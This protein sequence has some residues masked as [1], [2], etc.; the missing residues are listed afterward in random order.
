M[1]PKKKL[2]DARKLAVFIWQYKHCA[3]PKCL[4]LTFDGKIGYTPA[5]L[6]RLYD[7]TD[8]NAESLA[9]FVKTADQSISRGNSW[10]G[11]GAKVSRQQR[12]WAMLLLPTQAHAAQA[13]AN[14]VLRREKV[15]LGEI[16]PNSFIITRAADRSAEE[17]FADMYREEDARRASLAQARQFITSRASDRVAEQYQDIFRRNTA[18]MA[19]L[20]AKVRA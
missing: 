12:N 16:K 11:I 10:N 17:E 14:E 2:L 13:I 9:A 3:D 18:K 6:D 5:D 4:E 20:L 15:S 8:A 7:R 19:T 1:D